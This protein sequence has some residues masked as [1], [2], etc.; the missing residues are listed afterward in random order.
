MA[1]SFGLH[2]Q[3]AVSSAVASLDG[4][5]AMTSRSTS[6]ATSLEEIELSKGLITA[7]SPAVRLDQYP[8]SVV[9]VFVLVLQS[10]GSVLPAAITAA[11]LALA[12][13]GIEM[14]D[15]VS[16]CGVALVGNERSCDGDDIGGSSNRRL[17][18]IVLLADPSL[19][20]II[21]SNGEV[22]LAVMPNWRE[23]TFWEHTGRVPA[24]IS[25]E[26]IELAR[27]GCATV[28]K[29]MRECLVTGKSTAEIQ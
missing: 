15:L 27:D 26:A 9:D 8:K 13:A 22:T 17:K 18:D 20:E 23:V 24:T 7:V 14:F 11:S 25:S 10:D 3:T 5:A 2:A 1:P 4:S 6:A 12:D 16:S 28:Y 29:F 21:Q 19:S